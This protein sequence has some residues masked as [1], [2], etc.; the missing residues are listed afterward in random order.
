MHTRTI[1]FVFM[2]LAALSLAP[3]RAAVA[4]GGAEAP[5]A[6]GWKLKHTLRGHTGVVYSAAFL[7]DGRRLATSGDDGSV[8][9]WNVETGRQLLRVAASESTV[10]DLAVSP[11]GRLVVAAI[12][13]DNAPAVK[14]FDARTLRLV[15][16]LRGGHTGGL[17]EVAFSPNG[18]VL[19]S[20]G[21]DKT[22][23][24]WDV[25]TW[26]LLRTLE[27]HSNFVTSLAFTPD[28]RALASAGA[29]RD[30]TVMLWDVAGYALSH[31]LKGHDDW[32][33]TVAVS[34]DGRVVASGSRD[35]KIILWDARTGRRLRTF[36]QPVMVFE[37]EFAPDGKTFAQGGG[38]TEV[39]LH[40]A[41]TGR[42]LGALGGHSDQ[43]NDLKFSPRGTLLVT[44][45]YDGTLRIWERTQAPAPEP[46]SK[47]ME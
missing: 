43:I 6:P 47:W 27:G 30:N 9:V 34:P 32:V 40:D 37:I 44:A 42:L 19:A 33:T 5:A 21:K 20:G 36:T 24:L 13:D 7:P 45:S 8:R 29:E 26:R 4:Q 23:K 39:R 31:T 38:D 11:D 35:K 10:S 15:R 1:R 2:L 25:R 14:V 41:R 12:D 17:F 18:R 28:G 46:R 22:V 3:A 16:T